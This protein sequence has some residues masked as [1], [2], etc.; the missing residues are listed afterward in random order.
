MRTIRYALATLLITLAVNG[1]A[2]QLVTVYKT[3][4]CGCC[5]DWVDHIRANGF[6]VTT[7]NVMDLDQV[8]SEL[9]VPPQLTSCHTA[10]VGGYVIEGHV[11]AA[12]IK[13]LLK[14]RPKIS[15]LVVPQMPSGSPGMEGHKAD[16]YDVLMFNNGKTVGIY[17]SYRK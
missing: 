5:T 4:D 7:F 13:R 8:R 10:K 14:E 11:P 16:D 15:G 3:P 17:A 9:Q 2:G 1:Y 12:D 6:E